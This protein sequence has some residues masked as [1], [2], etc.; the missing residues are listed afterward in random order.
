MAVENLRSPALP[1]PNPSR[2]TPMS[3]LYKVKKIKLERRMMD[4]EAKI[5]GPY[6]PTVVKVDYR[7]TKTAITLARKAADQANNYAD[8]YDRDHPDHPNGYM[9]RHAVEV[10]V[11]EEPDFIEYAKVEGKTAQET[12]KN[13]KA[14][15]SNLYWATKAS[16]LAAWRSGSASP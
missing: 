9:P 7:T 12:E 6:L 5:Y 13:L 3:L 2:L 16:N 15:R 4:K 1:L 8:R 14:H 11:C 10:E